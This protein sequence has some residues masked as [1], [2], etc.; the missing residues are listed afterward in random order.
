M[1]RPVS[2]DGGASE[3]VAYLSYVLA[4]VARELGLV[5]ELA[6]ELSRVAVER[7]R[8]DWGGTQ[9]YIAILPDATI[10]ARD[11]EIYAAWV[12]GAHPTILVRRYEISL[13]RIYRILDDQK[14][15]ASRQQKG[16]FDDL[17]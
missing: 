6:D 3:G 17:P 9:I 10:A 2:R 15:L 7:I 14:K 16:L 5:G 8:R 11:A 1:D 12:K 4:E 13:S